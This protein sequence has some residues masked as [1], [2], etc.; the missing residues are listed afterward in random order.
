MPIQ[1]ES[2]VPMRGPESALTQE[3]MP[4]TRHFELDI[5]TLTCPVAVDA[6]AADMRHAGL[7]VLE[8][9][10]TG[11]SLKPRGKTKWS[12]R[13]CAETYVA[14]ADLRELQNEIVN[15]RRF[16]ANFGKPMV[17]SSKEDNVLLVKLRGDAEI[18]RQISEV[19]EKLPAWAFAKRCPQCHGPVIDGICEDCGISSVRATRAD[20]LAWALGGILLMVVGVAGGS[21][22]D[23]P[24]AEQWQRYAVYWFAGAAFAGLVMLVRSIPKLLSGQRIDQLDRALVN[25]L[26]SLVSRHKKE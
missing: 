18:E 14:W 11:L 2:D 5:Q 13:P 20:G 1:S 19:F 12:E 3:K 17:D 6:Y 23:R 9:A 22:L 26:R 4:Q 16:F 25:K 15:R 24:N 8:V 7:G 10:R 21:Y